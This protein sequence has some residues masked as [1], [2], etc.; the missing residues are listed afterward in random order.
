MSA[1]STTTTAT[2]P[3]RAERA[4]PAKDTPEWE[5][6][7]DILAA[8]RTLARAEKRQTDVE[9][10]IGRQRTEVK[11][12]LKSLSKMQAQL[13]TAADDV[14]AAKVA[15]KSVSKKLAE[16]E[17]AALPDAATATRKPSK[18]R[19]VKTTNTKKTNKTK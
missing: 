1:R 15:R 13:D 5:A 7:K 10:A 16:V 3:A 2:K 6:A 4:R 11:A 19:K 17:T 8:H 9:A 12:L 14:T 18:T